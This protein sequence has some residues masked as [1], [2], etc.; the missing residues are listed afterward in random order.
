MKRITVFVYIWLMA[1]ACSKTS[2]TKSKLE[3]KWQLTAI[4]LQTV[5]TGSWHIE[6]SIPPNFIQF[7]YDGSLTMSAYVSSL[8]NGPI[9]YKVASNTEMVF[10]YPNGGNNLD[11]ENVMNFKLTDTVLT[12]TPPS[13]EYVLEKYVRVQ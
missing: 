4:F 1:T 2:E 11:G 5:G 8:Y 3:G 9:G 7:N 10:N 12:I 6:D 13:M